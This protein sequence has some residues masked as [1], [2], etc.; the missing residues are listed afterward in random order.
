FHSSQA[1]DIFTVYDAIS[2]ITFTDNVISGFDS[3]ITSTGLA[4]RDLALVKNTAGL[5]HPAG[6]GFEKLGARRDLKVMGF[7]QVGTDWYPKVARAP[8]FD[9]GVSHSVKPGLNSLAD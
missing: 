3:R 7:D 9:T 8:R 4:R 2:G 6:A 5:S 1:R